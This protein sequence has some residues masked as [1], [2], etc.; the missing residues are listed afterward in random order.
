MRSETIVRL[1]YWIFYYLLGIFWVLIV[2]SLAKS[3][4]ELAS[5][6]VLFIS[7]MCATLFPI[8][9]QSSVRT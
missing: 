4:A 5:S 8:Y 6:L 1:E 7:S 3:N 2:S 9:V